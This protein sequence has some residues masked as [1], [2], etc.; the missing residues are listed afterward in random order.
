M[1]SLF[2]AAFVAVLGLG[3]VQPARAEVSEVT[4]ADQF[5]IAYLPLMVMRNQKL[6]EKQAQASGLST[7]N[8][9]W[10]KFGGAGMMNDA[11]LSGS[12]DI[13]IA[14]I[15]AL[16]L[17][18]DKTRGN[19]DVRGIAAINNTPMY[20]NTRNPAVKSLKDFTP[21]DRI[22]LPSVKVSIQAITL[23]MAAAKEFGEANFAKLDPLTVTMSHPEATVALLSGNSEITAHFTSPPF[24]YQELAKPGVHRVLS[25]KDVIGDSTFVLAYATS[26]FQSSNPKVYAAFVRALE[27]AMS[28]INANKEAA[29]KL[30]LTMTKGKESDLPGV[31]QMLS[32]PDMI[33]D[34]TPKGIMKYAEFMHKVG[35]LKTKPASWKDFFFANTHNLPGT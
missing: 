26:K 6:L 2:I 33:Y 12:V 28:W 31:L 15:P 18:W 3:S 10:A 17:L 25:S 11:L 22:A 4:I 35:L 30:Y 7:L 34:L 20:L 27:D 16:L 19:Y 23:E 13:G 5:G 8:V 14:G 29:A 32:D 1:K 9:K 21:K 24:M